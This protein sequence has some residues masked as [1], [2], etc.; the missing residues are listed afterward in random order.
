MNTSSYWQKIQRQRLSRRKMLAV[1]GGSAAG[2]AIAAACGGDGDAPAPTSDVNG[3]TP[4]AGGRLQVG[5]DLIID[6]LDP[7]TSIAGGP[8]YFPRIYNVLMAQSSVDTAFRFDDLAETLEQP[9]DTTWIFGI[10]P[11]VKIAPN[12]MGVPERD[13]D[14]ID[15]YESFERIRNLDQAN[16]AIF[17]NQWFDSHEASADGSTYTV[18]TPAPYAWFLYRIGL[19]INTIPPQ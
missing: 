7:H 5:T 11:G 9:D 4:A 14:A 6:T 1:T 15:A 16:A 3:G 12:E 18:R 2:L 19:F 8:T 17:V 10:R 13:M